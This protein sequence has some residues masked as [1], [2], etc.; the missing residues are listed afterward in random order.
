MADQTATR[1]PLAWRAGDPEP[2]NRVT[3]VRTGYGETWTR[4]RSDREHPDY[5][6]W[7]GDK[8]RTWDMLTH[9]RGPLYNAARLR[10]LH[11]AYRGRRRG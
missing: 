2:D 9:N 10:R 8:I 11:S 7:N 1:L 6:W 4:V 5:R 3:E